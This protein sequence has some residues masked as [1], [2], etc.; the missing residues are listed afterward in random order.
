MVGTL[1]GSSETCSWRVRNANED[2]KSA[3]S[4][5][6]PVQRERRESEGSRGRRSNFQ[7]VCK[8]CLLIPS[9]PFPNTNFYSMP[10]VKKFDI[11]TPNVKKTDTELVADFAYAYTEVDNSGAVPKFVPQ[12]KTYTFKTQTTVPKLGYVEGL[13]PVPK[14]SR[15]KSVCPRDATQPL[16]FLFSA[17]C[18]PDRPNL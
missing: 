2:R 15:G 12:T 13:M 7:S 17:P 10:L 5:G 1:N 11:Q 16:I 4:L 14:A 9:R 18:S 3:T 6:E 8:P